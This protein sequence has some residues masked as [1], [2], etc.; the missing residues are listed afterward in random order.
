[1][2][3]VMR[4]NKSLLLTLAMLIVVAALC[5]VMGFA[6]QLAMA[7]FA[8]AVIKDRKWAFAFP[9]FSM[10]VSDLIYHFMYIQGLTSISGFYPGQITNY[11]LFAGMTAIGFYM[12]KI[13]VRNIAF[14]SI[15]VSVAFFLLSNF[16]V[17]TSGAGL[18]RPHTFDGLMMCY[19][20][21]IPFF[22]YS[23]LTT[24]VFS[25]ILFGGW[26]LIQLW[27][28]RAARS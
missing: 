25:A 21:A 22:G 24:L 28:A 5:R 9:I 7:L 4:S 3:N 15:I 20:D 10:F 26:Q 2:L 16:F 14:F 19:A 13:S 18:A 6:P 17:W 12:K 8:G 23:L 11:V 27:Q 1:M